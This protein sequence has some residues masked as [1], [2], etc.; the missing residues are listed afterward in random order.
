MAAKVMDCDTL[1]SEFELQSCYYV[2][3]RT[4]ALGRVMN[5]FISP[6]IGYVRLLFSNKNVLGIKFLTKL[7]MPLN[8]QTKLLLSLRAFVYV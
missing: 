5:P 7:Y 2:H 6:T 3:F 4:S 1:V 8:K